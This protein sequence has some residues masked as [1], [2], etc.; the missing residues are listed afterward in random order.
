MKTTIN[1]KNIS[2]CI[3]GADG[4]IGTNL[5]SYLKDKED[6]SVWSYDKIRGSHGEDFDVRGISGYG[7]IVLLAT[8]PGIINCRGNFTKAVIDNISVAFN[9]LNRAYEA[10]VPVIFT[11][12][13]AAKEPFDNFY[14]TIKRIIECEALRLNHKGADNRILRLT[15]VY[16]GDGY[17]EK[18]NTVVK[19][20]IMARRNNIK[21][22]INGDG[23]QIRDLIHVKDVCRAIYKCILYNDKIS[24]PIDIGTG[25]GISILDLAKKFNH[26]FTFVPDSDT[27][28]SSESIADVHPAIELL[29]FDARE[30]LTEY[31][32]GV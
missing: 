31:L 16:G 14:A 4:Y 19:Q 30:S 8:F 18:K 12:S 28:G 25:I 1:Q 5:V 11:S 26:V 24:Q 27:I 15:N 32:K 17:L 21:M 6:V 22:V 29:G 20:F 10:Q 13:Q 9:I 7:V 23:S 3:I 2:A